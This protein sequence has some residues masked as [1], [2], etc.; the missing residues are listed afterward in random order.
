MAA[1]EVAV[2]LEAEAVEAT[3]DG[4][5][6]VDD[7]RRPIAGALPNEVE[8]VPLTKS[9]GPAVSLPANAWSLEVCP[10]RMLSGGP[11]WV[12]R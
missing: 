6:G 5:L 2:G 9:G 8:Q 7:E 4:P 10:E 11:G 12:A 3:R 1:A